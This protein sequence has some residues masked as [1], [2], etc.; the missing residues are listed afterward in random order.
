MK[1]FLEDGLFLKTTKIGRID[2]SRR[3]ASRGALDFKFRKGAI[4]FKMGFFGGHFSS[5]LL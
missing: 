4:F 3:D 5:F 2:A 1:F